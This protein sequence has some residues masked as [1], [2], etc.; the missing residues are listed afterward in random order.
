[1][2]VCSHNVHYPPVED[3]GAGDGE[4][5]HDNEVGEKGKHAEHDVGPFPKTSFDDLE[6]SLGSGRPGLQHDREDSKQDDLDGGAAS[7]PVGS[8]DTIL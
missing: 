7:V 2:F 5:H 4:W 6:E 1:M 8:T 3:R